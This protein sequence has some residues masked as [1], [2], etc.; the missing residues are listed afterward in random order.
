M[1]QATENLA[2]IGGAEQQIE[3]IS[4]LPGVGIA[5]RDQLMAEWRT[6]MDVSRGL[7][8]STIR[9]YTRTVEQAWD[10]LGDL[11]DLPSE[12]LE[13]WVQGKGG[14]SGTVANRICALTSFYRFLVKTKR[15]SEN[16]ASELDRPKL[17]RGVPKPVEDLE[18]VLA[19]MDAEDERANTWGAIPRPVGQTR[20]MAQF[21]ANTGLRIHEAVAM[22]IPVPA[23][24]SVTII[25]KGHKEAIVQL[26]AKAR[27]ASD[28]L[29][30]VWPI[31]ARATQR[32]FEKVGI[33]PHAL[34]HTFCTNLV[35]KGVEIGTVSKL[36]R[37]SSPTVT[38]TYAQYAQDQMSAAVD[39]L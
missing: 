11:K 16:P 39:L 12:V 28:F 32:R 22:A 27:E 4:P 20:M 35:R 31:G 15:R 17:H 8:P 18:A 13:R 23:P 2:P 36:A 3:K 37:H 21:L 9:L 5:G 30:G 19:R 38:M 6:W 33:H 29:G 10:D 26:N 14:R 34:R 25:G 24:S 7:L 1:A